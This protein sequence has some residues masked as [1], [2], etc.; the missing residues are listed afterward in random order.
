M[1][2][3]NIMDRAFTPETLA[4]MYEAYDLAWRELSSQFCDDAGR[5]EFARNALAQAVLSAAVAGIEDATALKTA[6]LEV[7]HVRAL[8]D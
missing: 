7:F 5:V 3:R 2:F 1:P 4:M 8:R 6:A